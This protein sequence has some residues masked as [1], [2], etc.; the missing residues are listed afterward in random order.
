MLDISEEVIQLDEYRSYKNYIRLPQAQL[1]KTYGLL[2]EFPLYN[3]LSYTK[4]LYSLTKG[5]TRWPIRKEITEDTWTERWR[6]N[7]YLATHGFEI[8]D[9]FE[10]PR[11]FRSYA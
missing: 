2:K 7:E 10:Y 9:K 5:S 3:S 8:A 11:K 4:L 6:V 1:F